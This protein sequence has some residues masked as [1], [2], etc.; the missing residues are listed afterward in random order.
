MLPH[1]YPVAD[2]AV[3]CFLG[4]VSLSTGELVPRLKWG[5]EN[6]DSLMIIF[7]NWHDMDFGNEIKTTQVF[8]SLKS[9]KM[10]FV[11]EQFLKC[12]SFHENHNTLCWCTVQVTWRSSVEAVIILTL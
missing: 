5:N 3:S 10:E 7:R 1:E 12:I 11:G 6:A 9:I 2:M 8:S 4:L